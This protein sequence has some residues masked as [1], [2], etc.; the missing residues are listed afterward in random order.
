MGW[1][2][3]FRWRY[4]WLKRIKTDNLYFKCTDSLAPIRIFSLWS[5][6]NESVHLK[7]ENTLFCKIFH[8]KIILFAH[9]P[10]V[11]R[12]WNSLFLFI[13][14]L[15]SKSKLRIFFSSKIS[16]FGGR[17]ILNTQIVSEIFS[18]SFRLFASYTL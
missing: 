10:M 6:I 15:I 16:I 2:F 18:I 7:P 11:H 1:Q 14:L 4:N 17:C 13:L 8:R 9:L 12:L 5:G 3:S